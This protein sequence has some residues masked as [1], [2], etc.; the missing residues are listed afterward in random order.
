M[1]KAGFKIV[2]VEDRA[3]E[4]ALLR[5]LPERRGYG[6]VSIATGEDCLD[7]LAREPVDL[8]ITGIKMPGISGIDLC[9]ELESRYPQLPVIVLSG[10][11]DQTRAQ[12]FA[13]VVKPAK[14]AVLEGA[15]RRALARE[16]SDA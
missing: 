16:S 6:C 12:A 4:A 2:I 9:R 14:L 8:V 10:I 7:H 1:R 5:D 11:A 3:D 13:H 15:I